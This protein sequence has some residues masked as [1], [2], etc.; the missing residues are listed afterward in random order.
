MSL[1]FCG[2]MA[3]TLLHSS[4]EVAYQEDVE[5]HFPFAVLEAA[6]LLKLD[7]SPQVVCIA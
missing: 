5:V 2:P 3:L 7:S 1:T 4:S 6:P